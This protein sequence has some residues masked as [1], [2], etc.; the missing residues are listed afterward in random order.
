MARPFIFLILQGLGRHVLASF[1]I[2][3]NTIDSIFIKGLVRDEKS[4]SNEN[5]NR[6]IL[7][8]DF[9]KVEYYYGILFR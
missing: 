6:I 5:S 1:K 4:H 9:F 7:Y 8:K 2:T 3:Q